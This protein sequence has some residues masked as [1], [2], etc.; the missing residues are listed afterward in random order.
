MLRLG[1]EHTDVIAV[2]KS[3]FGFPILDVDCL[4]APIYFRL[5]TI[6]VL[7]PVWLVA[8]DDPDSQL[9]LALRQF[10]QRS[11]INHLTTISSNF[12]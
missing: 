9:A 5:R 2:E 4:C 10:G 1:N 7:F 3:S 11:L 6:F 8:C 12:S